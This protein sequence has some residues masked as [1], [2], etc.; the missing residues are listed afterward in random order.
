MQCTIIQKSKIQNGNR[1]YYLIAIC[2][3]Y[4]ENKIGCKY[5]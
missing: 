3:T 5:S 4:F 2:K 1:T